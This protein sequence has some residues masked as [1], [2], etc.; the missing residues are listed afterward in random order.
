[1]DDLRERILDAARQTTSE[2]GWSAVTMAGLG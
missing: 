2:R 1:M